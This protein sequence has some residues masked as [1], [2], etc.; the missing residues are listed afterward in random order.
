MLLGA[1]VMPAAIFA[2]IVPSAWMAIGATCFVTFGHAFWVANLQALP[3]DL[4]PGQEVATSTGFSGSGGAVGGVLATLGT[5]WLVLHF[6]Y[7]PVFLIA[8]LM[9]PLS[10]VLIYLMLPDRY[11]R[12]AT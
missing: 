11:F 6:S 1:A 4:F 9:H 12:R 8:G 5:G 3:T 7:A 10:I 2:P